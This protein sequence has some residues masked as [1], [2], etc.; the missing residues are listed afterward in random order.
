MWKCRRRGFVS[1]R[2]LTASWKQRY[3]ASRFSSR[4]NEYRLAAQSL[5]KVTLTIA[6]YLIARGTVEVTQVDTAGSEQVLMTLG[7]GIDGAA[8]RT[9]CRDRSSG[10]DCV[11]VQ[12]GR[13]LVGSRFSEAWQWAV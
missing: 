13:P 7:S 1:C 11:R 12:V 10:A 9:E 6:F 2:C 3:R 5:R 4:Q 8:V